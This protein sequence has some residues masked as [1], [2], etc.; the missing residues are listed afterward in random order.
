MVTRAL[1]HGAAIATAAAGSYSIASDA[2][3][4]PRERLPPVHSALQP[5][6]NLSCELQHTDQLTPDTSRYR[7]LLPTPD[8]MLGLPIMS[9]LLAVDGAN[10]YRAYTP[11]TL[12]RLD[13]PGHFDLIVKRYPGGYFS[14]IF[15]ELRPGDRVAFRGPVQTLGYAPNRADTL[16]LICGG[17]G[18][19]PMYQL[20]RAVLAD[21]DDRTMLRLLY[22]CRDEGGLLLRRE[23][24]A[25]A[26][27]HPD[28]LTVRYFVEQG[29]ERPPNDA[30]HAALGGAGRG[31]WASGGV[32]VGRIEAG[33][34]TQLV[35]PPETPRSALLLCGPPAMTRYLC[36][37]LIPTQ[38]AANAPIGGLLKELG[39]GA[40]VFRF[41]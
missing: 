30:E 18:I 22:A 20:V 38:P 19:T 7:F 34:I 41:D 24:D 32:T 27:A 17:T 35:P 4:W 1:R 11:I 40:Q 36:G 3:W 28:R 26:A 13:P 33:A 21:P 29:S 10:V 6:R 2:F 31:A 9:H 23:L 25:L 12:D 39:Y 5:D 15:A 8:H 37:A 14:D 16:T